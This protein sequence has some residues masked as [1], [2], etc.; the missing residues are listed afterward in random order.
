MLAGL[1]GAEVDKLCETKGADYVD[2][3]KAKHEARRNA[4]QM[5]DQHYG[6]YDSY[7]PVSSYIFSIHH[8]MQSPH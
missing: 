5:Y 8:S 4:E 3:E 1:A 2:R 7:D 6:Q